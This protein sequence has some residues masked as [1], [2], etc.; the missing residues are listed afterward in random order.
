M[1]QWK[2]IESSGEMWCAQVVA[3]HLLFL[4]YHGTSKARCL[5]FYQRFSR[6]CALI[7]LLTLPLTIEI[8][9]PN[10][11]CA[12]VNAITKKSGQIDQM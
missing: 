8:Q 2:I 10:L 7:N 5:H 9:A 11:T 3:Q 1:V 6:Q 12:S 4:I